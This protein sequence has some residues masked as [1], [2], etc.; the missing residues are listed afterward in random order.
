M[1]MLIRGTGRYPAWAI[2]LSAAIDFLTPARPHRANGLSLHLAPVSRLSPYGIYEI[3]IP[4]IR[5]TGRVTAPFDRP[6]RSERAPTMLAALNT[7]VAESVLADARRRAIDV[8]VDVGIELP[9]AYRA[10]ALIGH[11]ITTNQV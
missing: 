3:G 8:I 10:G 4:F 7:S 2:G 9:V 6:L 5:L 1:D 11:Y